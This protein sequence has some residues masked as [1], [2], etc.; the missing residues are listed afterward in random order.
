MVALGTV[1]AA[2]FFL[3]P[4]A[5]KKLL[6]LTS[7]TPT[8]IITHTVQPIRFIINAK[9]RGL[10][11]SQ[12]NDYVYNKVEGQTTILEILAEGSPVK[13]GDVVVKLDSA[14]LRDNL[15]NQEI[16]T[17]QAMASLRNAELTLEVAQIAV[18][19]YK[20]GLSAQ[21]L[22]T[23]ES[24]ITLARSTKDRA[25]DRVKWT[26]EMRKK[27]YVSESQLTA[28]EQ[29]LM[30]AQIDLEKAEISFKVFKQ[31]SESRNIKELES[32]V[33]KANAD[34]LA[35]KATH[36]MESDK[37]AKLR[38][39]IENCTITAPH[40]GLIVYAN[41]P[42]RFGNQ[43]QPQI[44]E[45]AAIRESQK[46]FS[47]PDIDHMQVNTKVHES[48]VEKIKPGMR[49]TINV[50]AF[51]GKPLEGTVDHV[52]P[53]PDQQGMF[54]SDVKVYTAIVKIDASIP[55][56]R[57]GLS[58]EVDIHIGE[59]DDVLAVPLQSL[60]SYGGKTYV[61]V[62]KSEGGA[63]KRIVKIGLSN[64]S[65]MEILEGV[66]AGDKVA[67]DPESL[68][69]DAERKEAFGPGAKAGVAWAKGATGKG[70]AGK[71]A[72]GKGAAGKG[73]RKGAGGFGGMMSPEM[74][75]KIDAMSPA[76]K[77]EFRKS[78]QRGPGGGGPGGFGGGGPGGFGGR[79]PGG[80]GGG[81]PGGGGPG[82]DN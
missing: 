48:Q 39:Q 79:G 37:E 71:G 81:G 3:V 70:A 1:A 66:K 52:Q 45:G 18:E 38:K 53:L 40:D 27:K 32:D 12:K 60:L 28:D 49:A 6:G 5:G 17:Q 25:Q 9:D 54:S 69:T 64:D 11:E 42:N 73:F 14:T 65:M 10:L 13:K 72:A 23:Y 76:E 22:K 50:D 63:E 78:F 16:T 67:S 15:K 4:G 74:K 21:D 57:P 29:S 35:K 80:F 20:K 19:E 61:Y 30:Q 56:L 43:N 7:R 36:S 41:D 58:A 55:G 24:Q 34:Q 46:I 33:E 68:M 8:G 59:K 77:A 31:F 47:L 26:R 44:E 2:G 75:A 62:V 82:G 51:P